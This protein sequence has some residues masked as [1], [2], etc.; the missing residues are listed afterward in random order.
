MKKQLHKKSSV[1]LLISVFLINSI[2]LLKANM[3]QFGHYGAPYQFFTV[4]ESLCLNDVQL[5]EL[6]ANQAD[7]SEQFKTA[8]KTNHQPIATDFFIQIVGTVDISTDQTRGADHSIRTPWNVVWHAWALGHKQASINITAGLLGCNGVAPQPSSI[9]LNSCAPLSVHIHD[10][11]Y[12]PNNGQ[13]SP[14]PGRQIITFFPAAQLKP[15]TAFGMTLLIND[16]QATKHS[17]QKVLSDV[18]PLTH[19]TI[20]KLLITANILLY[21]AQGFPVSFEQ[22]NKPI[23]ED[24]INNH[25][26][27]LHHR[28][29]K[30]AATVDGLNTA[31]HSIINPE[32]RKALAHFVIDM[33]TT[34]VQLHQLHRDEVHTILTKAHTL[35]GL[36]EPRLQKTRPPVPPTS[37]PRGAFV[38]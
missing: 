30:S 33:L 6:I 37:R 14:Q 31:I 2:Y 21:V 1:M 15:R 27:S 26:R 4:Y 16:S 19:N 17:L 10:N 35:S 22:L 3:P 9:A 36:P 23:T 25:Q 20:E 5:S 24:G 8:L 38:K 11:C 7:F 32:D 29:P 34:L 12:S 13:F 18:Q 28:L